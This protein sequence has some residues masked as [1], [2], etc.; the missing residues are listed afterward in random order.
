MSDST[1]ASYPADT[2]AGARRDVPARAAELDAPAGGAEGAGG[3]DGFEETR[4]MNDPRERTLGD[5]LR[6]AQS[7]TDEQIHD[8][9]TYQKEHGVRF[10]VA[11]IRLGYTTEK[12]VMFALARQYRYPYAL[13]G[14]DNYNP[15]L[16]VG[17][18]PFGEQA[19]EFRELRSQLLQGVLERRVEG[20]RPALAVV[21]PNV[22]DGK[23]FFAANLATAFSQL[24]GRTVLIDADLRTPRL[25]QVFGVDSQLGLSSVLAGR[26][27]HQVVHRIPGIPSL[28]V[29]P[30]G[31]VP[32]NPLELVQGMAF[33]LLIREMTHRF[34][35]V[36]VDT[37]SASHGADCRVIAARCGAALAIGRQGKTKMPDL[38]TLVTKVN[39]GGQR[40]AGVVMNEW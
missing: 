23:T 28:Y 22:G 13:E 39:K 29:V 11:A 33:S 34:D 5:L 1:K 19:E 17:T 6:E 35:Y 37:P 24:G 38:Q 25:H 9:L 40:L 21:S 12:D 27:K 8:V 14:S 18:D 30:V 2:H 15:E 20:R 3:A 31:A 10:G 32:P 26:T 7:L 36:I 16:V 4:L